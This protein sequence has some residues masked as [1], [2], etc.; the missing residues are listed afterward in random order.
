M[1]TLGSRE[2]VWK[3]S[4]RV[5]AMGDVDELNSLIGV[6]LAIG[7][8]HRTAE[9]LSQIQNE[10]FHLGADLAYPTD[11]SVTQVPRIE[12]RHVTALE[13]HIDQINEEV[14]PLENFILPGGAPT[15]A[16]L[17]LARAVCRRAERTV[18]S[19]AQ[20]EAVSPAALRYLN[21]LS[22]ALFMI[23][24]LENKLSGTAEPLWDSH[25]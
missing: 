17:H 22:D 4:I 21:R 19:L 11:G 5:Q 18:V 6:A 1:T 23:A 14:G 10:L 13:G 15:A 7:P 2:R 25:R 9:A 3:G 24:R 16:H 20:A 8:G 12:D